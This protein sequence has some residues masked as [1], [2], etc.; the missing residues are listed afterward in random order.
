MDGQDKLMLL[1]SAGDELFAC[2]AEPV[3]EIIPK[4]KLKEIPFAPKPFAGLL[5]Y[6]GS[7]VPIVDFCDMVGQ[8]RAVDSLHTR[9]ILFENPDATTKELKIIGLIAE[10]V[11]E[12]TTLSEKAF[13]NPG[14]LSNKAPY[15]SGVISTEGETVQLVLIDVLFNHLAAVQGG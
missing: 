9:I 11:T 6:G 1:F 4:V 5:N 10:K 12:T 13:V 7:P 2:D 8:K 14:L 3:I 15:L